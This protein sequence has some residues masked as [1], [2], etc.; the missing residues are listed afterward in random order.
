MNNMQNQQYEQMQQMQLQ[1]MAMQMNM[2]NQPVFGGMSD[3]GA[4]PDS[5]GGSMLQVPMHPM[6]MYQTN[7]TNSQLA[8]YN[9]LAMQNQLPNPHI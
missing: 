3:T 5:S 1:G 8:Q 2:M 9:M 6:Q 4:P 7:F